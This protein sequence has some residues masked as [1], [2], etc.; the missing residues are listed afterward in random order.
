MSTI[1]FR[2]LF[3][4]GF[5]SLQL[6]A[7]AIVGVLSLGYENDAIQTMYQNRL[8]GIRQL[9]QV[10]RILLANQLNLIKLATE[11]HP[12]ATE[13]NEVESAMSKVGAI[14]EE[15][16]GDHIGPKEKQLAA[17]FSA[18][19]RHFIE[20]GIQP[21]ISALRAHDAVRASATAQGPMRESFIPVRT[22]VNALMKL[23]IDAA[24]S[25][26]EQSQWLYATVRNAFIGALVCGLL[27]ALGIG[28]WLV[29][30]ISRPLR[31]AIS[32]AGSVA[33]GDLT[34][35]IQTGA[36]DETGWLMQ[37]LKDMNNGLICI[38]DRVRLGSNDIASMSNRIA[39]SNRD[40]A[41]RTE[42]QAAFLEE[43]ASSMEQL[44][45]AVQQNAEHA[46]QVGQLA[47]SASEM[48]VRGEGAVA[49]MVGTIDSIKSSAEEIADIVGLIES[50]AFQTNILALNATV[51]AAHAGQHGA[52]F[53][54]VA[55]SVRSLAYRCTDAARDIKKLIGDAAQKVEVATQEARDAGATMAQLLESVTR[56]TTLTNEI[57]SATYEQTAGIGQVSKA[58][59]EI[60]KATQ[61]NAAQVT[62]AA[63]ASEALHAQ[64]DALAQTVAAFKTHGDIKPM[65]PMSQ[66]GLP[67]VHPTMALAE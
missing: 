38:V 41:T 3:V 65:R 35:D 59:Q 30:G 60:D 6:L 4:I 23:Q 37:A 11:Q 16:A 63:M 43:T 42:R 12:P 36:K 10:A 21:T 46:R 62:D 54:V 14:W 22:A 48:A 17:E 18:S 56:V 27:L 57:A 2:I 5:L 20:S 44:T 34:R 25:E 13:V 61:D 8:A 45:T 9:D 19:Y 26:Y 66:P 33:A 1:K 67:T 40:L 31:T 58:I 28:T 7:G 39:A 53:A 51:E 52:G 47:T 50:I 55:D 32:V 49:G 29:R 24:K 15:F 64:A